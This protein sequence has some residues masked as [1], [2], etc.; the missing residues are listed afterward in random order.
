MGRS[1]RSAG[2]TPRNDSFATELAR[3]LLLGQSV[4][5][6]NRLVVRAP[7]GDP[8][9]RLEAAARRARS[10]G[11]STAPIAPIAPIARSSRGDRVALGMDVTSRP[12]WLKDPTAFA[13]TLQRSAAI[14]AFHYVTAPRQADA[15][16]RWPVRVGVFRWGPDR[17]ANA[18]GQL[19][20][21]T[22]ATVVDA[23]RAKLPIELL[24]IPGTLDEISRLDD[25]LQQ[26]PRAHLVLVLDGIGRVS[27]PLAA[28][29]VLRKR[30]RADAV[31]IASARP[32]KQQ[33][34]LRTFLRALDRDLDADVAFAGACREASIEP[35]FMIA[36]DGAFA[37]A[38]RSLG[39][40]R[41]SPIGACAQANTSCPGRPQ[42]RQEEGLRVP[43]STAF[44][45]ALHCQGQQG[46]SSPI[47]AHAQATTS[48][49]ERPKARQEEGLRVP[50]S[51]ALVQA[52]HHQGQ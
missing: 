17:L 50:T 23:T 51:T 38:H 21:S 35:P 5:P 52:L 13:T 39:E 12:K 22:L 20:S 2:R 15:G 7:N 18:M 6:R 43:T 40:G 46:R 26:L 41:S 49:P 37:R 8:R 28:T 47:G 33:G 19:G 24:L 14:T 1:L 29:E 30:V 27:E 44:V 45:Q 9:L 48:C 11:A 10:M 34:I 16:W 42:A 31:C 32:S 4:D 25:V 3:A 36:C